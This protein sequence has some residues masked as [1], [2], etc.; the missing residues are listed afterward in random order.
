MRT[1]AH[2]CPHL[3]MLTNLCALLQ[4]VFNSLARK[5]RFVSNRFPVDMRLA[6]LTYHPPVATRAKTLGGNCTTQC[7]PNWPWALVSR[8][9]GRTSGMRTVRSNG[10]WMLNNPAVSSKTS[11]L[12]DQS[13]IWSMRPYRQH[14]TMLPQEIV[15]E[16]WHL[17]PNRK[18]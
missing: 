12:Q 2:S 14:C 17:K 11:P 16:S 18:R 6:S 13:T 9:S 1:F 15:E 7:L 5:C 3:R 4:N 10:S 8:L